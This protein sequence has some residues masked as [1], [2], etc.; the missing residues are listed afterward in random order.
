[1]GFE[2]LL[3]QLQSGDPVS[4]GRV[5]APL[6]QLDRNSR[7]LYD[8]F[9]TSGNGSTVY[10]RQQTVEAEAA[11]GMPVY[12]AGQSF[13]RAMAVAEPDPV[14]GVVRTA[15]ST[16]VWGI[17]ANKI[18]A[19]LADILLFGVAT[20]DLSQA[21][22]G[23]VSPGVYYLSGSNPGK[24]VRQRPP[25]SVAVLRLTSGG[26]V[27][28]SPQFVD[29]LDRHTHYQFALA[30]Q[31]AGTT[32]PPAEGALHTLTDGNSL[33]S[34][35]LPA[36][37]LVFAGKA[38]PGAVYGYNLSAH[39]AVG[40]IWPPV[41]VSNARL[42]WNKG[43]SADV[44]FTGVPLGSGGLAVLDRYGIWWMSN[45]YG[46]V[47]W[48]LDYDTANS[49]SNSY[50]DSIGAECPRHL[51]MAMTLYFAQANFAGNSATVLSLASGDPRVSVVCRD[52]P[53][54][55]ASSG[56]LLLELDLDLTSV[57][58][59][60]TGHLAFKEFDEAAG[61]FRRGP[62]AEGLYARSA[63]VTLSGSATT[64]RVVDGET[65]TLYHGPVGVSVDPA[66]SKELETQVVRL[67]GAE[68]ASFGEPP[69]MYLALPTGTET[70]FR[71][72][73]DVPGDLA[74]P[75]PRLTFRFA[76][77]GRA[78]GTLPQLTFTARIVPRPASGLATPLDLPDDP[79]EFSVTCPT[80]GILASSNQYVEATSTSFA[81][82]AGDTIYYTV[83]RSASDGYAG[84][85]GVMR[86]TAV[87]AAA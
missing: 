49:E 22:D 38:P 14:T 64:S 47:P 41:P 84:E 74:I 43:I 2:T 75:S 42:E 86:Q 3:Q 45:C 71:G 34:G 85:V 37:H 39:T 24:L 23:T 63:N 57:G 77:L 76:V 15:D 80:T 16:Q 13:V 30:C 18:N 68:D 61:E 59:D 69:I 10:A 65:R 17:V 48:P 82:T 72:R 51:E 40:N 28:V 11:V 6:N 67:D 25:V 46:D 35:W 29:F 5:N 31:P 60:T 26:Q 33:L 70:E 12:L 9:Q 21:V 87:V 36:D 32:Q 52:D 4:A 44:G 73:V 83:K 7:H 50:S 53:S 62:V 58:D 55:T 27:F 20:V 66:D 56:H 81:V 79:E 19:T 1:M 54:R 78:A 8:L